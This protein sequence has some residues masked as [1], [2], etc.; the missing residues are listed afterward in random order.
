MSIVTRYHS[1]PGMDDVEYSLLSQMRD[2]VP[3]HVWREN[4]ESCDTVFYTPWPTIFFNVHGVPGLSVSDISAGHT[5]DLDD[6]DGRPILYPFDL[7]Y[8]L[9]LHLRVR[10]RR[11]LAVLIC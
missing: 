11:L 5:F 3:Q 9:S 10:C 1:Y 2:M 4:E 7:Q 6:Y 8:K